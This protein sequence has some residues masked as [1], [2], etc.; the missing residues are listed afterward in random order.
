MGGV[1]R[2][3]SGRSATTSMNDTSGLALV[4]R[5]ASCQQE[6]KMP[7]G[8][9]AILAYRNMMTHHLDALQ[10]ER[11]SEQKEGQRCLIMCMSACRSGRQRKARGCLGACFAE[12]SMLMNGNTSLP[13]CRTKWKCVS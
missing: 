5:R 3:G 6:V 1:A 13:D 11:H 12:K 4:S 9:R 2:S 10:A 8:E 7:K